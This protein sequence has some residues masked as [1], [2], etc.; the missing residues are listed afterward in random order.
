MTETVPETDREAAARL[1]LEMAVLRD[2]P[3]P[4]H[5]ADPVAVHSALLELRARLDRAEVILVS[6][7]SLYGRAARSVAVQAEQASDEYDAELADLARKAVKQEYSSVHDRIAMARVKS[8]D[9][10][11][12]QRSAERQAEVMLQVLKAV[13]SRFY[14]LRDIRA[15]LLATLQHYLPWE[16]SLERT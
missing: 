14:G 6:V 4:P 9:A 2:F 7:R 5:D 1:L 10:R 3:V 16:A 12:R 8:L 13:E 15:E 11:R